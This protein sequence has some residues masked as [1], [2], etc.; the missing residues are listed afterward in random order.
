MTRANASPHSGARGWNAHPAGLQATLGFDFLIL[1]NDSSGCV[2]SD[3]TQAQT[4]TFRLPSHNDGQHEVN[5]S[6]NNSPVSENTGTYRVDRV[7]EPA[8]L[9]IFGL[10][11]VGLAVSRRRRPH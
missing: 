5:F 9:A 10:G 3:N 7:S 4:L 6:G 2:N 1:G 11:L 8:S